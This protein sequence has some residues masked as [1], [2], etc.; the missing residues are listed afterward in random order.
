MKGKDRIGI[1]IFFLILT[2][3]F[4]ISLGTYSTVSKIMDYV[5]SGCDMGLVLC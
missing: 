1:T 3:L 4:S 5:Q 2:E